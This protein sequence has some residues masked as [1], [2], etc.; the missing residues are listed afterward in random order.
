MQ[1]E[2]TRKSPTFSQQKTPPKPRTQLRGKSVSL[3][4]V[5][6]VRQ[7]LAY[8]VAYHRRAAENTAADGLRDLAVAAE[9]HNKPGY[10]S[11]QSHPQLA[12]SQLAFPINFTTVY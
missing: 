5:R 7:T 6:A 11:R 2:I 4:L 10:K 3:A 12:G 9:S 8:D 1:H